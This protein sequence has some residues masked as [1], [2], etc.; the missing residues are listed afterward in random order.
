[1]AALQ[2]VDQ[3]LTAG[4]PSRAH[5]YRPFDLHDGNTRCRAVREKSPRGDLWGISL[6]EGFGTEAAAVTELVVAAP[7]SEGTPTFVV[8][9]PVWPAGDVEAGDTLTTRV[10]LDIAAE[11]PLLQGG[12]PLVREPA[13]VWTPQGMQDFIA[14]LLDPERQLPVVAITEPTLGGDPRVLLAQSRQVARALAGLATVTVL[15]Q[16]FTYTL[17]DTVSKRLS[18]YDGAWRVYLPGFGHEAQRFDHPVYLRDRVETEEGLEQTT[19]DVFRVV[20]NY[21]ARTTADDGYRFDSIRPSKTPLARLAARRATPWRRLVAL[22]KGIGRRFPAVARGLRRRRA[23]APGDAETAPLRDESA[24]QEKQHAAAGAENEALR[25]DLGAAK[26]DLDAAKTELGAVK[27][28]L[29]A[30]TQRSEA[31]A[32]GR[33]READALRERDEALVDA[34]RLAG[35]VRLLGGDPQA[36]FPVAW[37]DV[38]AWC[39][40]ALQGR[41]VLADPVRRSL[42]GARFEDVA[43]AAICLHWLGHEYREARLRGGD[44]QLSGPIPGLAAGIRNQRCGGDSF[45][46]DW[47]GE[48]HRVDWHLKNGGNTRDPRRCLRIYYFWD[49]PRR[50]VV[51]AS[52]PAHRRSAIT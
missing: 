36:N 12:A 43:L 4:L 17:S 33:E 48:R 16:R 22:A 7:A 29:R 50:E 51:V 20:A 41:V 2:W 6:S 40:S 32:A 8:G 13:A 21:C 44:S 31:L 52:M 42:G 14:A 38:S 25:R 9:T 18:V 28:E 1:M 34:Q 24:G 27:A 3:R 26:A 10:L 30:A 23:T 46:F 19:R 11:V 45:D 5:S 47:R 37:G 15:P 35:L 49:A 39:A